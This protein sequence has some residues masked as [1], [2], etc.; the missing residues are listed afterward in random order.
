MEMKHNYRYAASLLSM[1][2]AGSIFQACEASL[3]ESETE[4]RQEIPATLSSKIAGDAEGSFVD[5]E[6]LLMVS[7]EAYHYWEVGD[8][9]ALAD[10][11]RLAA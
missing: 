11:D 5:D 3:S 1:I 10:M 6:L 4:M 8:S 2:C 9:V 7:E